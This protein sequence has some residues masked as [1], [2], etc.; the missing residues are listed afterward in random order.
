MSKKAAGLNCTISPKR[1]LA[2][3]IRELGPEATH[4]S[5]VDFAKKRFGM[6]LCVV[7]L[8]P[9][10]AKTYAVAKRAHRKAG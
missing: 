3:A 4:R 1:V 6:D 8:T 10:A 7:M 2:E 5:L 9:K